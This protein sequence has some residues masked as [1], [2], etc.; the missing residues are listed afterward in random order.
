MALVTNA[1]LTRNKYLP[2]HFRALHPDHRH[3][4]IRFQCSLYPADD[5]GAGCYAANAPGAS[6]VPDDT[7]YTGSLIGLYAPGGYGCEYHRVC[8]K[9]DKGERH[10]AGRF[11]ARPA[12]RIVNNLVDILP[13]VRVLIT[14][15]WINFNTTNKHCLTK[16]I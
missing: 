4:R 8:D 7:C 1:F 3:L 11:F 15:D 13:A 14:P 2:A 9:A 10:A 6:V 16:N 5:P 12:R